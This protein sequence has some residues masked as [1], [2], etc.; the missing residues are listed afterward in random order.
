MRVLN[1]QGRKPIKIWDGDGAVNVDYNAE[2]QL[3]NVASLPFTYKWVSVMP[4]V[5][6]G[7]GGP[8][9]LVYPTLGAIVPALVGVDI[10]C[11]SGETW[12][13]LWNGGYNTLRNLSKSDELIEVFSYDIVKGA[14]VKGKAVALKTRDNADLMSVTVGHWHNEIV[15]TPDHEFLLVNGHYKQ[16][17]YLDLTDEILSYHMVGVK[18]KGM[19]FLDQKDDVYCLQVE[20]HHNFALSSGVFVHNC[21][22]IAAKLEGVKAEH[23]PDNLRE[24]RQ[25]IEKAVPYDVHKPKT[26]YGYNSTQKNSVNLDGLKAIEAKYPD[27][28]KKRKRP[29]SDVTMSQAGTLGSGNHFIEICLDG[30]NNVW[31]MLHSGSRGIGNV[32]GTYFIQ[33]AKEDMRKHFI[34]LP[35]QDLAYLSE[36]T[37]YFDD[38][39]NAVNWAQNYASQNRV[40]MFEAVMDVFDARLPVKTKTY[41]VFIN[42]HHNYVRK[43][44]HYGS[45]VWVTRKGAVSARQGELG[46]IPGS[47]GD[48]SFIVVGKGN[49]ESFT[50]CAH[51]AGRIMSRTKAKKEF[52]LA[53]HRAA[54]SGVECRRDRGVL[55][56]TPMAYKDVEKVIEAQKDLINV[57]YELK[58]ILCV[59]G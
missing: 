9:G 31:V 17:K 44:N 55:D 32:I 5:H 51:G 54:V 52:T 38:Y 7:K 56:E 58:Q 47:M 27:L 22:M 57:E 28:G 10:G 39:V 21:G 37:E 53:E 20:D 35:D 18:V 11:F 2:N 40:K 25:A 29:L 19:K 33:K 46:V 4:D 43:E 45:N 3:R 23:L 6:L 34:N 48:K 12:I 15:C 49:P 59:K 30:A 16:A 24:L 1:E 14:V 36:G 13:P 8:I 26:E 50:S 42:C 41:E